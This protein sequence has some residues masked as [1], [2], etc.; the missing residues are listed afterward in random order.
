MSIASQIAKIDSEITRMRGFLSVSVKGRDCCKTASGIDTHQKD[1]D[2]YNKKISDLRKQK[3]ALESLI[4]SQ[5]SMSSQI[6]SATANLSHNSSYRND[7]SRHQDFN[8]SYNTYMHVSPYAQ[9]VTAISNASC[10]GPQSVNHFFVNGTGLVM[11]QENYS[12]PTFVINPNGF[13]G[14]VRLPDRS[15]TTF[16]PTFW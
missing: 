4:N 12:T 5:A 13:G 6:A 11:S 8:N 9:N 16:T 3:L 10:Y 7:M 14:A 15:R 1:I 2:K